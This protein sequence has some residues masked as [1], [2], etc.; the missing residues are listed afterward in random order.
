MDLVLI[1][2]FYWSCLVSEGDVTT[3]D[4]GSLKIVQ[5]L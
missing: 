5:S 2:F 3:I 4:V 1:F